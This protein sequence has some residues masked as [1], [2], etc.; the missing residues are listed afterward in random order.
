[1]C[2]R[3]SVKPVRDHLDDVGDGL[4]VVVARDAHENIGGLDFL[5]SLG[6]VRTKSGV[7]LHDGI[8][9]SPSALKT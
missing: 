7:V 4:L 9:P 3:D 1:M 5:D 2:I 8:L 6:G